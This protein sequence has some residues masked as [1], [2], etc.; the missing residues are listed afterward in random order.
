MFDLDRKLS[1]EFDAASLAIEFVEG[2]DGKYASVDVD[3]TP[4]DIER[5]KD[6]IRDAWGKINDMEFWRNLLKK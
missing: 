5:V 2:K 3:F 4:E 1:Y 6:E